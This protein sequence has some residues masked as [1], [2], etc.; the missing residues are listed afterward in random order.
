MSESLEKLKNIG[1]QKIHEKTH[2]ARKSVQDLLDENFKGMNSVQCIGF[3]SILEREYE[4]DLSDM[5]KKAKEYYKNNQQAS[6]K[7]KAVKELIVI[8]KKK[9]DLKLI[10]IALG[11]VLFVLFSFFVSES[12]QESEITQ[13]DNNA[14]ES[15]KSTIL[16]EQNVTQENNISGAYEQYEA[17]EENLTVFPPEEVGQSINAE[18]TQKQNKTEDSGVNFLKVVAEKE[19]WLGYIDLSD[20]SKYQ[21]TF[22]GEFELDA[23]KEW[24][25]YF[26]HGFISVQTNK[27]QKQYKT[28]N[29]VRFLYKNRELKEISSDEFKTLNRGNKW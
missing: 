9:R 1:V 11:V 28:Q 4:L 5:K 2:I 21:K 10:Y 13:V 27:E 6:K 8:N 18:T 26:G 29:S 24:L 16:L 12:S 7:E 14:I 3:L 20:Y 19:V 17:I 25:L 22:L 15:A 23:S